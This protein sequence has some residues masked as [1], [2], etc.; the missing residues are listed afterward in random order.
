MV[1]LHLSYAFIE[2]N[3]NLVFHEHHYQLLKSGPSISIE[4]KLTSINIWHIIWG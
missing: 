4:G 2:I 1:S 3:E